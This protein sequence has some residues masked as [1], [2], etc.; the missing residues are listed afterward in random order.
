MAKK[1]RLEL[2]PEDKILLKRK[3]NNN[4]EAQKYFTE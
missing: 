1:I 3:L 4:G 2:D